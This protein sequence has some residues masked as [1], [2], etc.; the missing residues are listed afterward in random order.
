MQKIL[1][2][3]S[4]LISD[5]L[6][7]KDTKDI[8]YNRITWRNLKVNT[9]KNKLEEFN[10]NKIILLGYNKKFYLSNIYLTLNLIYTI[11]LTNYNGKIIFMNTH[12]LASDLYR[13][14]NTLSTTY[15][16][17]LWVKIIQSF[18]LRRSI[19]NFYEIF[20]PTVTTLVSTSYKNFTKSDYKL[21]NKTF[22]IDIKDLHS[23]L[24]NIDK[25]KNKINRVFPFSGYIKDSYGRELEKNIPFKIYLKGYLFSLIK[26]FKI[27]IRDIIKFLIYKVRYKDIY[28][29]SDFIQIKSNKDIHTKDPENFFLKESFKK[30]KVILHSFNDK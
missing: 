14:E 3:G 12:T 28:I 17:Y 18:L 19:I 20:L 23:F 27:I 16:E 5:Y 21:A 9:L 15:T 4:G 11:K 1:I 30:N 26:I 8:F 25:D 2:I 7:K 22:F 6:I 24:I 13:F 10:P 29:K